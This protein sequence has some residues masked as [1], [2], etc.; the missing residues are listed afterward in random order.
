MCAQC[1][2]EPSG[3]CGAAGSAKELAN[4]QAGFAF[5]GWALDPAPTEAEPLALRASRW[6]QHRDLS[7]PQAARRLL[8]SI[9]GI[10]HG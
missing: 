10:R 4:L 1:E 8:A 7:D 9:R 6:G 3:T 5:A 2:N